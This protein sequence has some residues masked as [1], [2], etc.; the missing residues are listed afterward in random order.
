MQIYTWIL[1]RNWLI[2]FENFSSFLVLTKQPPSLLTVFAWRVW[3]GTIF[4]S[5]PQNKPRILT[6]I[7]G[8][9]IVYTSQTISVP[10]SIQLLNRSLKSF[11]RY[12]TMKRTLIICDLQQ[13]LKILAKIVERSLA[14]YRETH[15]HYKSRTEILTRA[16]SIQAFYY[17]QY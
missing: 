2:S 4:A 14:S 7:R 3:Y 8:F 6:R 5:Y 9:P 17:K 12:W 16:L 13:G 15:C 10:Y 11:K 1:E